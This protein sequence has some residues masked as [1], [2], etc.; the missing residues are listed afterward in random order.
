MHASTL[1]PPHISWSQSSPY[2][3]H[4]ILLPERL[5]V[6]VPQTDLWYPPPMQPSY[7]PLLPEIHDLADVES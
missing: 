7:R 5:L 2:W 4:I 3:Y 6:E 1:Q